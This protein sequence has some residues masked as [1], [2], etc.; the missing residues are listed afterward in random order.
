MPRLNEA[1]CEE[2]TQS[3]YLFSFSLLS[4]TSDAKKEPDVGDTSQDN[5]FMVQFQKDEACIVNST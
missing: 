3:F 4:F 5:Y 2:G 1:G